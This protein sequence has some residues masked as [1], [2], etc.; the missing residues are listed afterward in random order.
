MRSRRGQSPPHGAGPDNQTIRPLRMTSSSA[1]GQE[2]Q[3][4]GS[5]GRGSWPGWRVHSRARAPCISRQSAKMDGNHPLAI[6]PVR[7]IAVP[8]GRVR[9]RLHLARRREAFF[10]LYAPR[11]CVWC[12][13]RAFLLFG[14]S[15]VG[16]C[17]PTVSN[18]ASCGTLRLHPDGGAVMIRTP[19]RSPMH[20]G[21]TGS[22]L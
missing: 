18:Y 10:H 12:G 2:M 11:R 14:A 3:H 16:K 9:E 6:L 19:R 20:T 4:A 15:G 1:S 21:G 13:R 5:A 7:D 17:I 8:S 22:A